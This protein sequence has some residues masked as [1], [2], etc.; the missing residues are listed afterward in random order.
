MPAPKT[1]PSAAG[2]GQNFGF[3]PQSIRDRI[4]AAMPQRPAQPQMHP[5]MKMITDFLSK[6]ATMPQMPGAT[7]GAAP[8]GG[9]PTWNPNMGI[10]SPAISNTPGTTNPF[11]PFAMPQQPPQSGGIPPPVPSPI[12][13]TAINRPVV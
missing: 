6:G 13:G 2:G 8:Q 1:A 7:P 11:T 5:M 9:M 3:L 12:S 4:S 10:P